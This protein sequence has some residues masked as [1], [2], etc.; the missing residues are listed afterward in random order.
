MLKIGHRGAPRLAPA[1]TMAGFRLAVERGCDWVEC[2]CR[3]AKDGVVVLAHDPEVSDES[4][5]RACR[6]DR[7][8]AAELA[9]FDLGAGEGVP[10]LAELAEWAA[11]SGVGVMADVKVGGL[12][13][14][15][16]LALAALPYDLKMVA[17]ADD[18]GRMRFRDLDPCLPLS[19]TVNRVQIVALRN[20]LSTVDTE[21]VTLEY[22][23]ITPVR[24]AALHARKVRVFAW[25]T[26]DLR[27]MHRLAAMGVDGI[28]SN[29]PDL[30]AEL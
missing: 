28:I 16:Q 21:A 7:A 19:L 14:K 29:R 25:T 30:L 3:A 8:T 15:I 18:R 10:T 24:I 4:G 1:N 26:D 9:A 6:L 23:I 27:T 13:R 17:G 2:D 22:P 20:R 12:E 11:G 5:A